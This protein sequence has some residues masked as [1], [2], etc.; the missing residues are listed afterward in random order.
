MLKERYNPPKLDS[1][2]MLLESAVSDMLIRLVEQCKIDPLL[3]YKIAC[4]ETYE[5]CRQSFGEFQMPPLVKD[6]SRKEIFSI[7]SEEEKSVVCIAW[8]GMWGEG[9]PPNYIRHFKSDVLEKAS[10]H[11]DN[12]SNVEKVLFA[13]SYT[14]T[15][16]L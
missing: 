13:I 4:F 14:D 8:E 11:F 7:L 6:L 10:R 5:S 12:L 15:E 3:I 1:K 16:I 2:L 9:A